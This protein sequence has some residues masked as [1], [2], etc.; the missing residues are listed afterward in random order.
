MKHRDL[1]L[2]SPKSQLAPRRGPDPEPLG[3][4]RFG[5]LTSLP[6]EGETRPS[7]SRAALVCPSDSA[8]EQPTRPSLPVPVCVRSE[9]ALLAPYLTDGRRLLRIVSHAPLGNEMVV[10]LEDCQTLEVMLKTWAELAGRFRAVPA[11]ADAPRTGSSHKPAGPVRTS[12]PAR[13]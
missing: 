2:E 1:H 3:A 11:I 8:H 5:C 6:T 7:R 9:P 10:L 4:E 12:D 13:G